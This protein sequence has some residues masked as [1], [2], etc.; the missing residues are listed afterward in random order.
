LNSTDVAIAAKAL[1]GRLEK[2]AS[3]TDERIALGYRLTLGR[4]P[5]D[6]ELRLSRD[7]LADSPL[8]EFCRALFNVNEF[9]YVD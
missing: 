2:E 6:T 7:F 9:V 4:A 3:T 1:A 5:T 8:S